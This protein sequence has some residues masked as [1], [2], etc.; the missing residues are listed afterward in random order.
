MKAAGAPFERRRMLCGQSLGAMTRVVLLIAAALVGAGLAVGRAV[1][2]HSG[3]YDCGT[4]FNENYDVLSDQLYDVMPGGS[5]ETNCDEARSSARVLLVLGGIDVWLEGYRGNRAST[6]RQ[7]EVHLAR[8]KA[9]FGPMQ[10]GVVRPSHVRTWMA[11]L[12]AE[13]LADSYVY[14]L[15]ARLAQVYSDAVTTAWCPGRHARGVRPPAE[16]NNA[17]TWRPPNRCG[18]STTRCL[19]TCALPSCSER[20]PTSGWPRPAGCACPMW[21]SCSA[22][23]R[24]LCSTRPSR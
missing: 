5:G 8:I 2:V 6:V 3:D 4:A 19:S 15:H 22:P 24:L 13:G 23:F 12:A 14:A 1:P 17:P 10:V 7:A 20:S 18:R 21:T 9:A 11:Q 16:G